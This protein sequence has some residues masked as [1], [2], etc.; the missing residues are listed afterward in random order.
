M[1]A[2]KPGPWYRTGEYRVAPWVLGLMR[3]EQ[4]ERRDFPSIYGPVEDDNGLTEGGGFQLRWV[5]YR[6][7]TAEASQLNSGFYSLM[8]GDSPLRRFITWWRH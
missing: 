3:A 8:A 5:A 1:S 2:T 4:Q 6:P 7:S